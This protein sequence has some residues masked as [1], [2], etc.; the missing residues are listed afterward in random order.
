MFW[1][2]PIIKFFFVVM[3]GMR[4]A[5]PKT[6]PAMVEGIAKMFETPTPFRPVIFPKKFKGIESV[7]GALQEILD[8]K[9]YAKVV[10]ELDDDASSKL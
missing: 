6:I 1:Q 5:D 4:R 3:A 9:T 8:R 10:V 7:P 2:L